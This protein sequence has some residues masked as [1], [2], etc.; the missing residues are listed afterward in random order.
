MNF[1]EFRYEPEDGIKNEIVF[2]DTPIDSKSAREQ[3]QRLYDQVRD[4]LNLLQRTLCDPDGAKYVGADTPGLEGDTVALKL[5]KLKEI[6]DGLA[7]G[8]TPPDYITDDL[9]FGDI[10]IGSLKTLLTRD[11]SCVVKALNELLTCTKYRP[12]IITESCD[13]IVPQTG[14]Y[15]VTVVGG[16]AGGC[17]TGNDVDT[18]D[19]TAPGGA[20]GGTAIKWIELLA[21]QVIEVTVGK[22]GKGAKKLSRLERERLIEDLTKQMK[23]ASAKLEFEQAAYIRD[24]I[25]ELRNQ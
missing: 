7:T 5:K 16:G 20:S 21:D 19:P 18:F 15:K 24:K 3:F 13:F 10:K 2:P 25:K 17:V 14:L 6:C 11:K 22:G 8:V 9:L 12:Y 23:A 1:K 4:A